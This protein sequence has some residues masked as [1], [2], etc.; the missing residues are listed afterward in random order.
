MD[1]IYNS[2]AR[3]TAWHHEALPSDA[4]QLLEG[5]ICLSIHKPML[6]FFL[7]YFRCQRFDKSSLTF[8]YLAFMSVISNKTDVILTFL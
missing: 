6:D 1:R 5:Q 8:K 4:K 2:V 7:A 3:V